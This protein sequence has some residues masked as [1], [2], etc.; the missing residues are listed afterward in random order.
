[1]F[2]QVAEPH[3]GPR[4][5][6]L[7]RF[8]EIAFDS[9][10][11]LAAQCTLRRHGGRSSRCYDL[12][13]SAIT[14]LPLSPRSSDPP[15]QWHFSEAASRACGFAP[16]SRAEIASLLQG[17]WVAVLGDSVA[18]LFYGALLRVAN[19][20]D[21]G[22][23]QGDRTVVGGHRSFNHSLA[24]GAHGSFVW[25]PYAANVTDALAAW[26][27]AAAL[28]A[29]SGGANATAA[30]SLP[31][32][33]SGPAGRISPVPDI[34]VIC[35]SLWHM[36]HVGDPVQYGQRISA[37]KAAVEG[38]QADTAAAGAAVASA[39]AAAAAAASAALPLGGGAVAASGTGA[40]ASAAGMGTGATGPRTAGLGLG[41]GSGLGL[42]LG[43][44][45]GTGTGKGAGVAG[46]QGLGPENA[47]AGRRPT[48]YWCDRGN[49]THA[50]THPP[51]YP[52][53]HPRLTPL[54]S[55]SIS[56]RCALLILAQ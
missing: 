6:P 5:L 10:R 41:L 51:A 34:L 21:G 54:R 1:M 55:R 22:E 15:R 32:E 33:L 50:P 9:C 38:L 28:A 42:G 12:S 25:A 47:L 18:R 14:L 53:T 13:V 29:A 46:Q 44:A 8:G 35:S 52:P 27:R 45:L 2:V 30:T 36:L 4:A 20:E 3:F 16:A 31:D 19:A 37:L 48:V 24:G 11:A 49:P 7:L 17:K 40:S 23:G 39:A 43:L 56:L 26:R